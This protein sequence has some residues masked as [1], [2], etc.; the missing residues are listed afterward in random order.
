MT[1]IGITVIR[2]AFRQALEHSRCVRVF[3][4]LN[5]FRVISR[6]KAETMD[7]IEQAV[8]EINELCNR[9][10]AL[11]RTLPDDTGQQTSGIMSCHG[12]IRSGLSQDLL[13]QPL[14]QQAQERFSTMMEQLQDLLQDHATEDTPASDS[15]KQ[16][17]GA[18][19]AQER[20]LIELCETVENAVE[21]K[22]RAGL[23]RKV[24]AVQ[25]EW[26]TAGQLV[27]ELKRD[28]SVR[29]MN[30]CDAFYRVQREYWENLGWERWANLN[31]K[32]ELCVAVEKL[33]EHDDLEGMPDIVREAQRRWKTIGPVSRQMSDQVWDRFKMACDAVYDKCLTEKNRLHDR[34]QAM[35]GF[36]NNPDTEPDASSIHWKETGD[37]L[38]EIQSQWNRIGMLPQGLEKDLRKSFQSLCNRFFDRQRS[39]YETLNQERLENLKK[40][41][42]LCRQAQSFSDSTDW[43]E[44]TNRLKELQRSWKEIGPIPKKEGDR[45]W[46][47][48]QA[49]CNG[50]FERMEQSKPD[51]VREKRILCEKVEALVSGLNE[52]SNY[53]KIANKLIDYQNQ[54]KQIGPVPDAH[55]DDLWERFH[56]RCDVFF[57]KR[58]QFLSR[59]EKTQALNREQK[60]PLVVEVE[61]LA[62]STDWKKT[63]ERIKALQKAWKQ[64]GPA[65]PKAERLLRER[66][67][68]ACD[69]FFGRRRKHFE[70]LDQERAGNLEKKTMLCLTIEVLARMIMTERAMP[71]TDA[72]SMAEQLS[73]AL[74]MKN[75][76]VVPG[77]EKATW[78][79]AFQRVRQ[80]Q[81]EWKRIGPV[82]VKEEKPL[83]DR[84]RRASDLFFSS[85]PT[86]GKPENHRSGNFTGHS[87]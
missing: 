62:E 54:W 58:R 86:S 56:S 50:F 32:K 87:N 27:P 22:N 24:R 59:L 79:R 57:E 52:S 44:T 64:I 46:Q 43:I 33:R 31:L 51:N 82:P 3:F 47:Q 78:D 71:D 10:D 29:F 35:V 2:R 48:F 61:Q 65:A 73:L 9:I 25:Q 21:E 60:E 6:Q 8:L 38:K 39:F 74:E 81:K 30:A 19:Q 68:K 63:G 75:E 85:R 84:F 70:T 13:D 42:E 37:R 18:K 67:R 20:R 72:A 53:K 1:P 17:E 16:V 14:L 34:V 26:K 66:F 77:D 36:L 28:F 15:E 5:R 69:S 55:K 41:E 11:I 76:I 80:V 40:K 45:L 49:A 23:E 7:K 12:D 83:W 4:Q